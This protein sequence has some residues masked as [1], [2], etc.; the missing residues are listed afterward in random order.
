MKYNNKKKVMKIVA[1]VVG[2]TMIVSTVATSLI[3]MS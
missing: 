2:I 1:I 3:L